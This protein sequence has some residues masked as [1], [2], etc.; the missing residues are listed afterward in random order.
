MPITMHW[1][2]E[3]ILIFDLHAGDWSWSQYDIAVEQAMQIIKPIEHD[4]AAI[5]LAAPSFPE[6][7]AITHFLRVIKLQ[8]ANLTLYIVVG[9]NTVTRTINNILM[10]MYPKTRIIFAAS[11]AEAY[12]FA[13]EHG[14]RPRVE[15]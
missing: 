4:V 12:K 9:G 15:P 5:V 2:G 8:P 11:E 13:T 6:G 7:N 10:Q 3:H 1:A 14:F